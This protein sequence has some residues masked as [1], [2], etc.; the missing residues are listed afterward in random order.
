MITHPRRARAIRYPSNMWNSLPVLYP[1]PARAEDVV[2]P[3][4][5]YDASR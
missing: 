2:L 1:V 5:D 4:P 3:H